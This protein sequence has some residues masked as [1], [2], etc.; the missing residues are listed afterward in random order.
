M[1]LGDQGVVVR[2]ALGGEESG[3]GGGFAADRP[4]VAVCGVA[5]GKLVAPAEL[6]VEAGQPLPVGAGLGVGEHQAAELQVGAAVAEGDGEELAGGVAGDGNIVVFGAVEEEV[7]GAVA[8][9]V[10]DAGWG[11]ASE[12]VGGNAG[13][14]QGELGGVA[15]GEGQLGDL[16]AGD[17][18][19][20][21]RGLGLE[22][23]GVLHHFDG[24]LSFAEIQANVDG[25]DLSGAGLEAAGEVL[26][27]TQGADRDLVGAEVHG[28][29]TVKAGLV[30]GGLT[31]HSGL[32]VS[33]VDGS[34]GDGG[35]GGVGDQAAHG[36]AAGLGVEE[37]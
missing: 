10:D 11:A 9:A 30:G 32:G 12:A 35:G 7:V 19:A 5:E 20:A 23:N 2:I 34:A 25:G 15:D 37:G 14:V 33:Q 4:E 1:G 18:A 27:E 21:D 22:Q 17:V 3:E 24:N 28:V 16:A 29:E 31:G 8:A 26:F 36:A 13:Q 6:V